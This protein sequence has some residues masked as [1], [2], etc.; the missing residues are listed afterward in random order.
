MHYT[1]KLPTKSGFYFVKVEGQ[2]SGKVYE[3]VVNVYSTD[4][5]VST[6]NT[7]FWDGD[8]FRLGDSCFKSFAGPIETPKDYTH[9]N[10]SS[11]VV[12]VNGNS[13]KMATALKMEEQVQKKLDSY[14]DAPLTEITL[15]R[16]TAEIEAILK[17]Y[18]DS[19]NIDSIQY[20]LDINGERM[21]FVQL[22][23][24]VEY[25]FIGSIH[26]MSVYAKT[27]D[28]GVII[29]TS[30]GHVVVKDSTLNNALV[31]GGEGEGNEI[32]FDTINDAI[33][34]FKTFTYSNPIG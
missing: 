3:T 33:E 28:D 31:L 14:V 2:L 18:Q 4:P 23:E 11:F 5:N 9:I 17:S 15:K 8:N 21:L 10:D 20:C 32:V 19:D 30:G 16:I 6:P 29:V 24:N 27:V 34:A 12:E 1:T 13:G 25:T 22:K 7:V 26:G